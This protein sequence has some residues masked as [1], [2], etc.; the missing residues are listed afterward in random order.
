MDS[1]TIRYLAHLEAEDEQRET[2]EIIEESE[3]ENQEAAE[4]ETRTQSTQPTLTVFQ[5]NKRLKA[6]VWKEYIPV[7]DRED[8]KKMGRCMHCQKKFCIEISQGTSA[9]TRHLEVCPMRGEK[10]EVAR[11][12][13]PKVDRDMINEIIIY[14][15][16]PFKYVE[17]EKVRA[18][19]IYLNP[20][21]HHICRQTAGADV[22]KRFELEKVK[23]RKIFANHKGRVCFTSDMWSAR[24]TMRSYICL[25][26]HF[27]DDSWRLHNKILAFCEFEAPHT[28]EEIATKVLDCLKEWGLE[29]KVFSFTLD[30]ATSNT[31][32][33]GILKNRLTLANRLPCDGKFLHVRCSAH[34]LNLIVKE[35]LLLIG[36]LLENIR[37]S[38]KFVKASG[39]RID[40]FAAYS[41]SLKIDMKAGLSLD[42]P[43]RWNSTYLMLAR[44]LKYR[45]AFISVQLCDRNYK[46]LPSE[47]EWE[48]GEK[49]RDL[50]KPFN[51][52]T[53]YFSGV[54][55]PTAN[56]Y[57]MQVWK[58]ELLLKKFSVCDDI[59][60]RL[61]ALKMKNKFAKYWD[62]YSVV[63]A[64]AAVL[65][66]RFKT[67]ILQQAYDKLDPSTSAKKVE[68]V[69][70]NL[71]LLYEEYKTKPWTS[72]TSSTT[73][74]PLE[75]LTE[76]PLEDDLD[77][78]FFELERS[79]N[80]DSNMTKSSLDLYLEEPRLEFGAFAD[81]E[82][83]TYWKNSGN[84]HGD[85][86]ALASDLLS[87]PIT[88]VAAESAFSV[89]G[90]VL[91]PY[92]SRLLPATVQA[93]LCT[94][95]WL[96]GFADF[97]G[98][99]DDYFDEE[100]EGST[101]VASS[102]SV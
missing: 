7:G 57:F 36:D 84:R 23:L 30:N 96:R 1:Q 31:S 94:R 60:V 22:L 86:T 100:K 78:D 101:N 17:Y 37:N 13:D 65:D 97:D 99:I 98:D 46:T 12:Y 95:N 63:L 21:C 42:V 33:L 29:Q 54:K 79:A 16:L 18:R 76:S 75:L 52:I 28:G 59:D 10:S 58:I 50:L 69:K 47:A 49:I 34:I 20:D 83:L 66:P 2:D 14:H 74:T 55:Y 70:K 90:R 9:V 48:R 15:D 25:T 64:M 32:M 8:G 27:V 38:V 19:D 67:Q 62:E 40:S 91:N 6:D 102:S 73:L 93:L 88:T 61:M 11:K 51:T 41:K 68:L 39:A 85:L 35:G 72:S 81:I 89:G 53:T 45:K 3:A 80:L 56:I 43:T 87:I 24:T 82:V 92:R 77:L 26:A 5:S 44:A 4:S 71:K